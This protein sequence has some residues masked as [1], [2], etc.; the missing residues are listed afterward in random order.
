MTL[1]IATDH[2]IFDFGETVTLRQMR[3]ED[4]VATASVLNCTNTPLS[5]KQTQGGSL[6]ITGDERNW[7][8]NSTNVGSRGVQVNDTFED[9]SGNSWIVLSCDLRTGGARWYCVCR[10]EV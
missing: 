9:A 3:S 4:G 2:L 1:N 8:L 10:K 6:S 7:S 5:R